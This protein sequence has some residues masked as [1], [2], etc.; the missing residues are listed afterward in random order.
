MKI[1]LVGSIPE[2]S[3]P[4]FKA[5]F[6]ECCSAMGHHFAGQGAEFVVGG[7]RHG[8][9]DRHILLGAKA[10]T[11][12]SPETKITVSVVTQED[13]QIPQTEV[14]DFLASGSFVIKKIG[15]PGSS[16]HGRLISGLEY[17]D[18]AL[19]LGGASGTFTTGIAALAMKHPILALPQ[20]GHA[21]AQIWPILLPYYARGPFSPDDIEQLARPCDDGT[22]QRVYSA[23]GKIAKSNPLQP[24]IEFN[25]LFLCGISLF[26]IAAWI[27]LF[28][29]TG[30]SFYAAMF[31]VMTGF[32]AGLGSTTRQI[33]RSYFTLDVRFSLGRFLTEFILGMVV[34][35]ILFL[36]LQL[37]GVIVSGTTMQL[38]MTDQHQFQRLAIAM[39]LVGFAASYLIEDS[40]E[41]MRSRLMSILDEA[42]R[43]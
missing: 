1:Y 26:C 37:G 15:V 40:L 38:D 19:L 22:P 17:S 14:E 6:E 36:V 18:V 9:A 42:T 20:F 33:V 41:R 23:L 39:S 7:V 34:A 29:M 28:L 31:F 4:E 21:A 30:Q 2:D 25:Q 27:F 35:F 24:G 32:A 5:R 8:T 43:T 10:F 16:N 13:G 12:G 3:K 11:E